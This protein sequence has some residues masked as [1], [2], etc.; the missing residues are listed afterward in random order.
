MATEATKKR[1]HPKSTRPLEDFDS[2]LLKAIDE[3]LS[4]LGENSKTATYSY[5]KKKYRI[6]KNEI[7]QRIGPFSQALEDLFKTGARQ[8]EILCMKK[9]YSQ[10]KKTHSGLVCEWVTSEVTF[11]EYVHLAK[12][13]FTEAG[14]KLRGNEY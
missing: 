5:L 7:P 4:S 1:K 8:L 11:Q 13:H 14:E 3:S 12:Q 9:L 6:D 10:V 2:L